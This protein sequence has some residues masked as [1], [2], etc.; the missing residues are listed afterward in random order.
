MS[1]STRPAT[2]RPA[3]TRPGS[4]PAGPRPALDT[5]KF[6]SLSGAADLDFPEYDAPPAEP[7]GLVWQWLAEAVRRGVREPRSMA[8]ATATAE[9]RASNRIVTIARETGRGL[10][11]TTHSTSRKGRELAANGWASAL[12][13]WRETGQQIM[14]SGPVTPLAPAESDAMWAAR[15]VPLHSMTA[16][17]HQSDPVEDVEL[18]R[19]EAYRLLETGRPLPRPDRFTGYLLEP[20]EVEFWN[21]ASDRLHRRLS[22]TRTDDGRWHAV[23]LQP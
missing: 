23:R 4:G 11:F 13:Y 10:V 16:V 6:E 18:L 14:L 7:M 12:L 15:P 17:S 2:T 19:D 1:T 5:S 9:G 8:L 3:P 22:Y 21:A 20:A